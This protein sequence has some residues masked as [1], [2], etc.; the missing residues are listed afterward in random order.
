MPVSSIPQ[1]TLEA[2]MENEGVGG[3]QWKMIAHPLFSNS[4]FEIYNSNAIKFTLLNEQFCD[5]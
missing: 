3:T 5:F 2:L 1:Q 4:V